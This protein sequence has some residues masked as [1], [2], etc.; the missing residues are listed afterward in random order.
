[1]IS[2]LFRF[3]IPG[4]ILGLLALSACND[5]TDCSSL[6]TTDLL[7]NFIDSAS[8]EA[9]EVAIDS[10]IAVGPEINYLDSAVTQSNFTLTVNPLADSTSYYFIRS[11]A[12]RDTLTIGYNVVTRLISPG[13]GAE[14]VI[15]QLVLLNHTFDSAR[16]VSIE[17]ISINE[18][19]VQII[20]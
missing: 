6:N 1:M 14:P 2:K 11:D 7:V 8:G 5:D 4:I 15:N 18:V 20:E 9:L 16:V 10:I 12:S 13:C 17:L 3:L 19:D